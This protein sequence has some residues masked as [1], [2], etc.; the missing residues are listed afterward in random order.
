ML[1][2]LVVI[3]SMIGLVLLVPVCTYT[4]D[5]FVFKDNIVKEAIKE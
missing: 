4:L 2:E 5:R 3:G 1:N